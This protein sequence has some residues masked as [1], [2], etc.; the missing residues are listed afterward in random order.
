MKK[1]IIAFLMIAGTVL[2]LKAQGPVKRFSLNVHDF[3]ELKVINA[4]NVEYYAS[5]D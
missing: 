5:A 3:T 4:I 1:L 2:A